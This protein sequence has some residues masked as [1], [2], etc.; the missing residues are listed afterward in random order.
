MIWNW[1]VALYLFLAGLGAG[2]FVLAVIAG[3]KCPDGAKLKFTGLLIALLAVAIG[4]LMLM[5]DARAGLMHPLRFFGLLNNPSSIMMWGVVLLTVFLLVTFV[6]LLIQ[7]KKK[8]TPKALDIVGM[9]LAFGVA[10]YTGM[11]LGDASVAFPLWNPILLPV[12]FI[13]SAASAGFAAVILAGRIMHAPELEDL[14]FT[15]KTSLALPVLEAVLIAVLLM[16]TQSVAGSA[17]AA[18]A[19]S[20]AALI[21]GAYAAAFWVGLIA[22]GLVVPFALEIAMHKNPALASGPAAMAAE[23][24]VLIGG[25]MLRFLVIYAAVAV[26]AA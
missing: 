12:L 21:G 17:A 3:W 9:V 19:A 25:F 14:A 10:G 1:M 2:A 8:V 24:C 4:T 22:I 15:H 13:V 18:A 11:L 23:C 26:A 5:V 6:T 20:V 16:V 7:G